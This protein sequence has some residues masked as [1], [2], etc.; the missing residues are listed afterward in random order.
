MSKFVTAA[1]ASPAHLAKFA[2]G[3]E[4]TPAAARSEIGLLLAELPRSTKLAVILNALD[5]PAPAGTPELAVAAGA[6]ALAKALAD[7][8]RGRSKS[9]APVKAPVVVTREQ[10]VAALDSATAALV[11]FDAAAAQVD[12]SEGEAVVAKQTDDGPVLTPVATDPAEDASKA[13]FEAIEAKATA[14]KA[15]AAAAAKARRAVKKG[16]AQAKA[17]A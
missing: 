11:A 12:H 6:A 4:L 16:N 7:V 9:A 5:T 8:I 15:K 13:E 17:Q 10:L 2:A 1:L 14:R 3:A